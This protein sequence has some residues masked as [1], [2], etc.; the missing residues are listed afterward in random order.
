[1]Q[2]YPNELAGVRLAAAQI[3]QEEWSPQSQIAIYGFGSAPD[4]RRA[5]PQSAIDQY[6]GPTELTGGAARAKLTQC[7]AEITPRTEAQGWNTDFAAALNQALTVLGA[8]QSVTRL[9]LVFILT[10]GQLD[11]GPDSPYSGY[12]SS[13]TAGNIAAQELI[14]NPSTGFLHQLRGIGAEIWP[15]GFGQAD[16]TQLSVFARG[17]AQNGCPA[18]SGAT[19][20]AAIVPPSVTGPAEVEDIQS[21][22]VDTFAEARCAVSMP[23]I[24]RHLPAGKSVTIPFTISPLVTFGS[25]IVD[26]GDSRVEVTY[27]DPLGEK[28]SDTGPPSG[29]M[30]RAGYQ[31]TGSP[32]SALETLRLDNPYPGKWQVTFTDPPGVPAQTVGL[33]VV[34]QGD[35][36]L[37]FVNQQV[38]DPGYPYQLAV[39]PAARSAPVPASALGGF[40]A[41]FEVTW[42]G[43]QVKRVSA[44]LDADG[45]FTAEIPVPQGLNGTAHVNA[46]AVAPGVQGQA[47][48][49]FPV[50]PGGGITVSL[51]L[52]SGTTVSPGGTVTASGTVDT[53]GL[54]GTSIVFSL[55]GLA[56]GVYASIAQPLGKVQIGSGS[57]PIAVTIRFH[58]GTRLGPA[59]GTIRWAPGLGPPSPSDWLGI[60]PLDVVVQYRPVPLWQLW[61]FL[62]IVAV[63]VAVAGGCGVKVWLGKHEMA[64]YG[65]QA[66]SAPRNSPYARRRGSGP[67]T[68]RYGSRGRAPKAAGQQRPATETRRRAPWKRG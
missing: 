48:A 44:R 2:E 66:P 54:P 15:V 23:P 22:L 47:G 28:V 20:E 45:D 16:T 63:V 51:K 53:N 39:Q 61:W 9:P 40:T 50:T 43:G 21:K 56:D 8:P 68:G 49:A 37:E 25:L 10:D 5:Q 31:L 41:E 6:C 29:S 14:T 7:A 19:P 24:W 4:T 36:Q 35:L 67:P 46:T 34:W 65:P 17:G 33:S 18:G 1:M 62:L 13:D 38:G 59:T 64:V 55:D 11:V 57:T 58:K 12:G 32:Q 27:T 60:S 30:D 42:P 26:K 52:K 3:V